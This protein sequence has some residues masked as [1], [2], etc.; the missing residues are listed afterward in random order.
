MSPPSAQ[1]PQASAGGPVAATALVGM[2]SLTEVAPDS[3]A[4]ASGGDS[5]YG[6]AQRR[7]G[8]ELLAQ[9]LHAAQL[10]IARGGD[11][12]TRPVHSLHAYFIRPAH[13]ARE[14]VYRVQRIRD[15]RSFSIRSVEG[16]QDDALA[17]VLDASFQAPERG[18]EHAAAMPDVPPPE[19]VPGEQSRF[20]AARAADPG[21]F[22]SWP[23]S[24]HADRG[25]FETRTV[26]DLWRAQ[27][28]APQMNV[29]VRL[30]EPVDDLSLHPAI[31]AYYS[32]DPVMDNA[33]LPH[34]GRFHG[35][36]LTTASLDH[37]MWF[38]EQIDL[39][40]WHLFAQDSPIASGAR[41]LTRG[42]LFDR[43]GRLVASVAQEILMRPRP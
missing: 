6:S 9:A 36:A 31:A 39:R 24:W 19:A 23:A 12:G 11:G 18:F 20:D 35:G 30:R 21:R 28:Y 15:G 7:F 2:L 4:G 5:L 38:H 34:L 17:F 42:H 43:A 37:A 22:A 26:E 29:W 40:Q 27:V 8:G 1:Q 25:P 10:T 14:V 13:P 3:Y 41:G 33:L 16:W 32:D